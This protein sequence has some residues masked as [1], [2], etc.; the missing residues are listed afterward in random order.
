MFDYTRAAFRKIAKDFKTLGMIFHFAMQGIYLIYLIYALITQPDS[1]IINIVLTVLATAYLIFNIVIAIKENSEPNA[2]QTKKE[3]KEKKKKT[4][5]AKK[6]ARK[7]YKWC[8]HIVN[9]FPL[10]LLIYNIWRT[11]SAITSFAVILVALQLAGWV[12]STLFKLTGVLLERTVGLVIEGLKTDVEP[13]TKPV[14][15]TS[16][17]FKRI[18]GQEVDEPTPPSPAREPLEELVEQEREEKK[19][20][21]KQQK[22]RAT[23]FWKGLFRRNNKALPA[24]EEVEEAP[25]TEEIP[26]PTPLPEAEDELTPLE[27]IAVTEKPKF[28]QWK[29]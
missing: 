25:E 24:S 9:L 7:I 22:E 10:V 8:K 21:K 2:K 11:S 27:E 18:T 13:L 29:K 26:I 4:K 14:T 19:E 1:L 3:K 23:A 6:K 5:Q 16:N 17:F 28:W 20:E 12:L 15:A